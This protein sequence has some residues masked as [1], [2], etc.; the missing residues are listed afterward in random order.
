MT[1]G[2]DLDTLCSVVMSG[3]DPVGGAGISGQDDSGEGFRARSG[4]PVTLLGMGQH[5]RGGN[6]G[7]A[8]EQ[9]I[10][11]Q[12]ENRIRDLGFRISG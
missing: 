5:Q 2:S 9:P 8:V 1:K 12:P 3:G 4:E 7:A 11:R 6:G 10:G